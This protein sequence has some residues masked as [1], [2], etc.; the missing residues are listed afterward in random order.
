VSG[1]RQAARRAVKRN[2]RQAKLWPMEDLLLNCAMEGDAASANELQL[3]LRSRRE[4]DTGA[5]SAGGAK[6]APGKQEV[7]EARVLARLAALGDE[8]PHARNL[9]SI[10]TKESGLRRDSTRAA[11]KRLAAAGRLTEQYTAYFVR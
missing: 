1:W 10:L 8:R 9:V 3:L 5:R 2:A 11:L 6:A 4:K 7:V